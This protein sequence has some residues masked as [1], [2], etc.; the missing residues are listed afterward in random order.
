MIRV[1][2]HLAKQKTLTQVE[3]HPLDRGFKIERL[4]GA[5]LKDAMGNE[6]NALRFLFPSRR[7]NRRAVV[8]NRGVDADPDRQPRIIDGVT[9]AWIDAVV[10][11]RQFHERI[12]GRHESIFDHA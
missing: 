6:A 10:P 12:F 4:L 3:Q 1:V 11:G 8:L 9:E 2:Q 7:N 5:W